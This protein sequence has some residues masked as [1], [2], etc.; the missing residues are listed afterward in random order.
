LLLYTAA[1]S[2]RGAG[3]AP[4]E[5]CIITRDRDVEQHRVEL[6]GAP[7]ALIVQTNM[8]H[9]RP[10]DPADRQNICNSVWRR[11]LV[12]AFAATLPARR[13]Y[14]DLW[15]MLRFE[16]LLAEDTVCVR[17]RCAGLV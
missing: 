1:C 2:E 15:S 4:G 8:D 11:T 6:R 14:D 13:S 5:G 12:R 9:W 10:D 16:P 7:S 3:V 17:V